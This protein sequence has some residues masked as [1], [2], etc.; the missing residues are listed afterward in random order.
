M[1]PNFLGGR[2]FGSI[3]RR[4]KVK[5]DSMQEEA[6]RVVIA[7][8]HQVMR[9]GLKD[10]LESLK[11]PP[12]DVIAE[13]ETGAELLDFLAQVPTDIILLDLQMPGMDGLEVL[14]AI[15]EQSYDSKVLVLSMYSQPA[16][17]EQAFKKGAHGYVLKESDPDYILKA[18]QTILEDRPFRGLGVAMNGRQTELSSH[19]KQATSE[20]RVALSDAYGLT[21]RELE[22][23]QLI[24]QALS[25]SAIAKALGISSQTV[26]VHRKNLMRKLGV[27][28][29]VGL[30]RIA[31]QYKIT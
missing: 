24:G 13:V 20:A 6:I 7:D 11:T 9:M 4:L 19:Q 30:I 21:E 12:F 1:R 5:I 28:N 23:L 18:I 17:V 26:S 25:N 15:Q 31:F 14:E 10:F 16:I 27:S 8:D 22:V 29:S 2:G 3:F